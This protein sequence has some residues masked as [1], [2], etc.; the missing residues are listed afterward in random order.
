MLLVSPDFIA[1]DYCYITELQQAI[2]RHEKNE[3]KVIPIAV[4]PTDWDGAPFSKLQG[5]P[6][7]R[8]AITQWSVGGASP[9]ENRDAAWL[10]VE[11]GI[12]QA[13]EDI[14]SKRR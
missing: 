2:A 14:K 7:D 10:N 8:R 13:I 11:Q 5:L 12:K 1:S 4:R 6:Q 3:A 9:E